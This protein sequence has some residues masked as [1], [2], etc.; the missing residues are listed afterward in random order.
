MDL[1]PPMSYG[2]RF[3][4]LTT[5]AA[6]NAARLVLSQ[7]SERLSLS[8]HPPNNDEEMECLQFGICSYQAQPQRVNF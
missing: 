4:Q 6:E 3:A 8:K 5:E 7:L 2:N 1:R